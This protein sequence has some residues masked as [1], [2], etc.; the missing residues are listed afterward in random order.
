MEIPSDLHPYTLLLFEAI[1]DGN[2]DWL[3]SNS[4]WHPYVNSRMEQQCLV[5]AHKRPSEYYEKLSTSLIPRSK[6]VYEYRATMTP[7]IFAWNL[8][9]TELTRQPKSA[10]ITSRAANIC[11]I[12][13]LLILEAGAGHH[14]KDSNDRTA[15][16][17]ASALDLRTLWERR[18][19][20]PSEVQLSSDP[21]E[22]RLPS[23][24]VLFGVRQRPMPP[25]HFGGG[26]R[27]PQTATFDMP[28]PAPDALPVMPRWSLTL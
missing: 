18:S 11:R 4:A 3:H 22:H 2:Y 12:A 24:H 25:I 17:H 19:P 13:E 6:R 27:A 8:L 9:A 14:A 21:S 7:L 28:T 1:K 20:D 23:L 10:G 16:D 15:E 26:F 5:V